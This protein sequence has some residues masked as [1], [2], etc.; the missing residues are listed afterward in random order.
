LSNLASPSSI[1][2]NSSCAQVTS[3][4]LLTKL[5]ILT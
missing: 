3:I 4:A 2:D 1:P 5:G